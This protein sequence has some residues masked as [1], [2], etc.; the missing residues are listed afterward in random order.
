VSTF[1]VAG[2]VHRFAGGLRFPWLLLVTAALFFIDL[3]VPDLLPFVDEILLGL[4]TMVLATWRRRKREA[5][6]ADSG[7]G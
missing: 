5:D 1:S 4:A 3:F 6:A 7:Q 2:L